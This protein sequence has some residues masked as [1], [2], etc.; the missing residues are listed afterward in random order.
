MFSCLGIN[1]VGSGGVFFLLIR[2]D[3]MK[4]YLDGAPSGFIME[5][6]LSIRMIKFE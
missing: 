4:R 2:T 6:G 1:V 5:F 3:T